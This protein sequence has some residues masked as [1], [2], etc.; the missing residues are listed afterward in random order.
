MTPIPRSVPHRQSPWRSRVPL[1]YANTTRVF[2][3]AEPG[4]FAGKLVQTIFFGADRKF[5]SRFWNFFLTSEAYARKRTIASLRRNDLLLRGEN[6]LRSDCANGP[7]R[8]TQH[9]E[10]G[11]RQRFQEGGCQK[12]PPFL[13]L[14]PGT[15]LFESQRWRSGIRRTRHSSPEALAAAPCSRAGQMDS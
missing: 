6:G 4:A 12:R 2:R 13:F 7:I 1:P 9:T 3:R 15:I 5:V 8:E 14:L 11:L 10:S